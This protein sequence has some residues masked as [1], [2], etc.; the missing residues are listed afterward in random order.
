MPLWPPG[1][2]RRLGRDGLDLC[3]LE[4]LRSG[5]QGSRTRRQSCGWC[6]ASL[7]G[8]RTSRSVTNGEV[9]VAYHESGNGETVVLVPGFGRAAN[10]QHGLVPGL[11]E[12]GYRTV[13]V[14]LRGVGGSTG[15]RRPRPTLHDLAADVARVVAALPELPGGRVHVRG[16]AFGG[17]TSCSDLLSHRERCGRGSIV[18]CCTAADTGR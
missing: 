11:N 7:R 5:V 12:A 8:A 2:S 3:R 1:K 6:L 18:S 4:E 17:D 15:P 10:E 14:E 13:A 9:V 16:R